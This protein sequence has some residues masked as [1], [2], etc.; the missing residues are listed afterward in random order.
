MDPAARGAARGDGERRIW[1]PLDRLALSDLAE[2]LLLVQC[3]AVA[4]PWPEPAPATDRVALRRR[5]DGL[6]DGA[7]DVPHYGFSTAVFG[8][9]ARSS[10]SA[11]R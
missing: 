6:R 5:D 10:A 3:E 2:V 1:A 11:M 9:Y 8:G 4:C 7:P